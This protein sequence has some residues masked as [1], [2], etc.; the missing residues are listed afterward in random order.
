MANPEDP[1]NPKEGEVLIDSS[2]IEIVDIDLSM[3]EGDDTVRPMPE[4]R[5]KQLRRP[6]NGQPIPTEPPKEPPQD[7]PAS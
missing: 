7:K 2:D 5:R 6:F 1:R 3:A 4:W